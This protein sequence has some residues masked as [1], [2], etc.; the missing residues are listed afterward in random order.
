MVTRME[1]GNGI[2]ILQQ[3]IFHA[4]R[5]PDINHVIELG[6][7]LSCEVLRNSAFGLD[8]R[9]LHH[10]KAFCAENSVCPNT[11]QLSLQKLLRQT[12]GRTAAWKILVLDEHSTE[13]IRWLAPS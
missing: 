4:S 2:V 11:Y 8:V 7:V 1:D 3:N 9:L 5:F 10:A 13:Y 6:N 12:M